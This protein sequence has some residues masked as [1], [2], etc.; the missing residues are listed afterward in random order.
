MLVVLQRVTLGRAPWTLDAEGRAVAGHETEQRLTRIFD[1]LARDGP[2]RVAAADAHDGEV[3]G[4]LG[5]IHDAAYLEYLRAASGPPRVDAERHAP[6]VRAD[7]PVFEGVFE[8]AREGVRTAVSAAARAAR[9]ETCAY[10]LCRPPG[11]HAGWDYPGGYCYL[12]NAVAAVRALVRRG[13]RPVGVVDVDFHLGNGTADVLARTPDA[14]FASLHGPTVEHFP[15]TEVPSDRLVRALDGP[16]AGAYAAELASVLDELVR[17]GCRALV[18][19]VGYDVVA[20]DPH[21]GWSLPA[22]VWRDVGR[23]LRATGL[24]LCLVQEGGYN[25]DV[26]SDCAAL[27][28]EGLGQG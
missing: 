15:W 23:A 18:A 16:D 10:A 12:N 21:G 25:L 7:T 14:L 5:E 20:G 24:P 22:E 8:L 26:L 17:A 11:H 1:G 2:H 27:L 6:G 3:D 28:A 9:G 19:S 13:V 4:I